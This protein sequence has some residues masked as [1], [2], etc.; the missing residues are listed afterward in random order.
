MSC[1]QSTVA[2]EL[3]DTTPIS[4]PSAAE[5]EDRQQRDQDEGAPVRRQTAAEQRRGRGRDD[6]RDDQRVE[7]WC[8][9]TGMRRMES[10]GTPLIL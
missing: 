5:R 10:A 4:A 3:A 8:V 7:A 6:G 1:D 2:R 9:S